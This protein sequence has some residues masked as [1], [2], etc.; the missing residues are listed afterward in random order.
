MTTKSRINLAGSICNLA[1]RK[2][3][4]LRKKG[5]ELLNKKRK[6]I[7]LTG[8]VWRKIMP[9]RNKPWKSRREVLRNNLP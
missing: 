6:C 7:N 8:G 9:G 3:G 5:G 4:R 1:Q 2:R